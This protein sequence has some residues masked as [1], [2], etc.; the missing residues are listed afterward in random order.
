METGKWN[1]ACESGECVEV[2]PAG[3]D[4]WVRD[5]TGNVCLFAA[6][7]WFT[8]VEGVKVGKF[9]LPTQ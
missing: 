6:E 7:E 9:D 1:K 2:R 3:R 8:F 4:V 5:A